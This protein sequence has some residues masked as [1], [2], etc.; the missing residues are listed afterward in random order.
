MARIRLVVADDHPLYRSSLAGALREDASVEV[1]D[2]VADGRAATPLDV[3]ERVPAADRYRTAVTSEYIDLYEHL[4]LDDLDDVAAAQ[5]GPRFVE[6]EKRVWRLI[7]EEAVRT[8][9]MTAA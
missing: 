6:L 5:V 9:M 1:V 3:R 4:M 7:E 2:E 8:G